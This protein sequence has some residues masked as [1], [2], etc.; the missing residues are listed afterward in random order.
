MTFIQNDSHK[1]KIHGFFEYFRFKWKRL[2][3]ASAGSIIGSKVFF[4]W[5]LIS[6]ISNLNVVL[7]A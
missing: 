7:I 1:R 3:F 4:I 5:I 2:T 6:T